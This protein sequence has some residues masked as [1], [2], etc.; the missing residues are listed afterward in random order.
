VWETE[1]VGLRDLGQDVGCI[2]FLLLLIHVSL[3]SL[4]GVGMAVSGWMRWGWDR[5][6]FYVFVSGLVHRIRFRGYI[7]RDTGCMVDWAYYMVS[8]N[9]IPSS[10]FGGD[11]R[12][13]YECKP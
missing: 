2:F 11:E 1:E 7:G 6:F 3:Y 13:E 9:M 8:T 12:A 10:A 4:H 5:A